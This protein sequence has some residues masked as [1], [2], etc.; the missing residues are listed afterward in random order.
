[1][2]RQNKQKPYVEL[3]AGS[4]ATDSFS[5]IVFTQTPGYQHYTPRTPNELQVRDAGIAVFLEYDELDEPTVVAGRHDSETIV[6]SAELY[7]A[8]LDEL[9][10]KKHRTQQDDLMVDVIIDKTAE[11]FRYEEL[12]LALAS[13]AIGARERHRMAAS[14]LSIEVIGGIDMPVFGALVNEVIA[15]AHASSL[16]EG[17]ELLTLLREQST[18]C[19][20]GDGF[21][22]SDD[23]MEI[24]KIDLCTLFPGLDMLLADNRAGVV[25]PEDAVLYFEAVLKIAGRLSA[26]YRV[27]NDE[28]RSARTS[29]RDGA[30]Y[31]GRHRSSFS[32]SVEA[33]GV[34]VHEIIGHAYRSDN[35]TRQ[36]DEIARQPLPGYLDFEEGLAT[37]FEQIITGKKRTPGKQYYMSIGLQAGADKGGVARSYRQTF[38]IMWRREVLLME[39]A[40]GAVDVQVARMNAQRI[41]QR[42][43]RGG[44]IDTR[45]SSY[46]LGAKKA[47]DWLNEVASLPDDM[48]L[49]MLRWVLSAKFDPTN[50]AHVRV[51]D[52]M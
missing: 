45:D 26:E 22:L 37:C 16:P 36:V 27:E 51:V 35:A 18:S 41:V 31:I 32:S 12:Q 3:E 46:F 13:Q 8:L 33:V 5:D 14:D 10:R 39:Q 47:C 25:S 4:Q 40:G 9:I 50:E 29:S 42:T 49:A 52:P 6:R 17:E 1:M 7:E 23:A 19:E 30:I 48:R 24:L 34:G 2:N 11:L 21:E 20:Y 44:A 38:E 28:G 43:R 15:M